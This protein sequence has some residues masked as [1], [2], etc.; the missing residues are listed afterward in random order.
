MLPGSPPGTNMPPGHYC[1]GPYSANVTLQPGLFIL[2]KGMFQGAPTETVSGTGVTI[3]NNCTPSGGLTCDVTLNG[4]NV[5]NTIV[6]ATTGT[7]GVAAGNAAVGVVYY[8]PPTLVNNITVDGAAGT[9]QATGG[10]YAPSAS[11]TFNGQLPTI[12]FI[13][14]GSITMNGG[15]LNVGASNG[16]TTPGNAVLAE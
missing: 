10:V 15:G 13:V 14:A 16:F 8:Q 11:F 4:G 1:N 7:N 12:S 2:D 6:A 9:V 5:N 3:Y